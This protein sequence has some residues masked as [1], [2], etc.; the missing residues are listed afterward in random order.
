MLNEK[1]KL[2]KQKQLLELMREARLIEQELLNDEKDCEITNIECLIK[3]S[4][5]NKKK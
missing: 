5:D 2:E 3:E 4:E 1:E